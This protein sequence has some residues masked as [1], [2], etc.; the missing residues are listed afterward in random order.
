MMK[1]LMSSLVSLE[2]FEEKI[3][4]SNPTIFVFSASWCPDCMF[5]KPFMP[6]LMKK[7]HEFNFIYVDRD[8]FIDLCADLNVLGIPSFLAYRNGKE[9]GRFVGKQRKTKQEIDDF[10]G[11]CR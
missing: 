2:S 8:S 5:I 4:S 9:I 3:Q 11:V 1:S 7:Y 10:F 6:E